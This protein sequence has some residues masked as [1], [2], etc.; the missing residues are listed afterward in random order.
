MGYINNDGS[1]DL[2][3]LIR[4]IVKDKNNVSIRAGGG[5][6]ADLGSVALSSGKAATLDFSGDG[7]INFSITESVDGKVFGVD[8]KEK[9][10]GPLMFQGN[11]GPVAYRN[12]VVR[13]LN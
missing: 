13:P 11:H 3:I 9:P 5:I 12:I 8:G 2:N 4:T 1:M 10:K 6:V 7:L